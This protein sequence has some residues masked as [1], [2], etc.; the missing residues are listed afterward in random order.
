MLSVDPDGLG[1]GELEGL[2]VELHRQRARLAAVSARLA[3]V[4]DAR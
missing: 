1:D 3:A 2:V 4:A